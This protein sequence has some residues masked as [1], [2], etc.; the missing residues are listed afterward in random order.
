MAVS[1][2]ARWPSWAAS[3]LIHAA[4]FLLLGWLW[5]PFARGTGSERDRPIGIA[6]VH[7]RQGTAEYFLEA[8]GGGAAAASTENSLAGQS[9]QAIQAAVTAVP[10][11]GAITTDELLGDFAATVPSGLGKAA[12]MGNQGA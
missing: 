5:Q 10:D 12:E 4:L 1:P 11:R 9:R 7:Q 2:S 8:G 3:L 6:I